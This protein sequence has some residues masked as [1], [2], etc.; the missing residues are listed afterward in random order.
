[1]E[2]PGL[3]QFLEG[4]TQWPGPLCHSHAIHAPPLLPR[5]DLG[6]GRLSHCHPS[7]TRWGTTGN[8][9]PEGLHFSLCFFL[10]LYMGTGITWGTVKMRILIH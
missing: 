9:E 3:V 8:T 4:G 2:R 5:E 6:T 10:E 7:S 1:M